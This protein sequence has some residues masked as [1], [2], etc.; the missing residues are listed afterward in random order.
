[1]CSIL[2]FIQ[3]GLNKSV[4]YTDICLRST[5]VLMLTAVYTWALTRPSLKCVKK[6]SLYGCS[7]PCGR[8]R[9]KGPNLKTSFRTRKTSP[10]CFFPV[11][12]IIPRGLLLF[13]F[14]ELV[15]ASKTHLIMTIR[16]SQHLSVSFLSKANQSHRHAILW[17]DRW[18]A[19]KRTA[20]NSNVVSQWL[21]THKVQIE[22]MH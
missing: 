2:Q 15:P 16:R 10:T 3:P 22:S 13:G 21:R 7:P 8:L 6:S 11:L 14:K 4:G 20:V 19:R 17:R 1:M 5:S 9:Q 18:G 12:A